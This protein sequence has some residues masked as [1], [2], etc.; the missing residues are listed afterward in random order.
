MKSDL[1]IISKGLYK[2]PADKEALIVVKQYI[3]AREKGRKCLMLRFL[4]NSK[5]V[6][7]AFEFWLV[8]KN[9]EGMEIAE[10]KIKVTDICAKAGE[11][12]A[13]QKL[14]TVKDKCVDFDIRVVVVISG[15]Y[16]YRRENG[17]TFVRYSLKE[18]WKYEDFEKDYP[19]QQSK[20]AFKVR[21]VPIILMSAMLLVL[22]SMMWPFISDVVWPT[23]S[24]AVENFFDKIFS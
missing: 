5:T 2:E 8:Q 20:L 23:V 4:N 6:I 21:F 19:L 7:T 13:P 9:S 24:N 14:F 1:K 17:D 16:E 18:T 12:F 3:F 10:T 11:I 15:K 22:V